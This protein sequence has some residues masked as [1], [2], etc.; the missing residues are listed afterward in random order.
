MALVTFNDIYAASQRMARAV[1]HTSLLEA[2]WA[3]CAH[4]SLL[5]KP[6]NLQITGSFKIRG[7]YNRLSRLSE[8]QK[9]RGIIA[10]SSGNHGKALAY[11]ARQEG[12]KVTI[13]M[14]ATAAKAKV[15]AVLEYGAEVKFAPLEECARVTDELA[16]QH[17]FVIIPP[18]DD[19]DIIAGQG[20]VGLEIAEEA[21]ARGLDVDTVLVP[22]SGGGLISGVAAALKITRPGVR[23]VGVEPELAADARESLRAGRRV[24]WPTQRVSRT[25]A[26]GMQMSTVGVHPFEHMQVLVDD[27][28]TVT[29]EEICSSVAILAHQAGMIAEPSGAVTTAAYLYH[30]RDLP[31]G[32]AHVAVVSGGN[33]NSD[34]LELLLKEHPLPFAGCCH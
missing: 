25:L 34:L 33:V 6:E 22:V 28:I 27:I 30:E 21:V 1:S 9:A 12:V 7:A 8:A 4:R 3:S 26:D 11:V 18:F 16:E 32:A 19:L 23:V 10:R 15:D 14:P 29:E 5:L 31:A 13:V 24:T 20:T 2:S 17:G